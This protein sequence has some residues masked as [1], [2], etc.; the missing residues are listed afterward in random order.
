MHMHSPHK[1][2]T[3]WINWLGESHWR[4]GSSAYPLA[5]A[6]ISFVGNWF[7]LIAPDDHRDGPLGTGCPGQ[8]NR[9]QLG[10]KKPGPKLKSAR[11]GGTGT[12]LT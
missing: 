4:S 3:D 12:I 1:H 6:D 11:M 9:P 2:Q 8:K 5:C 7:G 10:R